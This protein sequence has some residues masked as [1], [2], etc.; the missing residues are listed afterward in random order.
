MFEETAKEDED[1]DNKDDDNVYKDDGYSAF[2]VAH[3]QS[4]NGTKHVNTQ[5]VFPKPCK[6]C[7]WSRNDL[8]DATRVKMHKWCKTHKIK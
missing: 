3:G 2:T 8:E 4:D 6:T 5:D 7:K 1:D